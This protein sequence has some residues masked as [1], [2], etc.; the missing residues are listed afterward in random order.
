MPAGF[1]VRMVVVAWVG[2]RRRVSKGEPGMALMVRW[3]LSLLFFSVPG[4]MKMNKQWREEGTLLAQVSEM[5]IEEVV[6]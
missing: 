3:R 6:L 4:L 2:C 5:L 1:R